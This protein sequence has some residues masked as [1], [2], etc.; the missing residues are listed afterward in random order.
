MLENLTARSST[1]LELVASSPKEAE[2]IRE[3]FEGAK[4]REMEKGNQSMS[5]TFVIE[6]IG[7]VVLIEGKSATDSVFIARGAGFLSK[8]K[9]GELIS[10]LLRL[11]EEEKLANALASRKMGVFAHK[12]TGKP[13][14]Q[15]E[16]VHINFSPE[17]EAI[18]EEQRATLAARQTRVK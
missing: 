6:V 13:L 4:R 12:V 15:V 10:N 8:E 3:K 2:R 16:K 5:T 1:K 11:E 14:P 17:A 9:Q 7:S 18:L